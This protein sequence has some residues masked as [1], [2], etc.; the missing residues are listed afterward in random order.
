MYLSRGIYDAGFH[1][2]QKIGSQGIP[3]RQG[4]WTYVDAID[5]HTRS[6]IAFEH[7]L[8]SFEEKVK[9]LKIIIGVGNDFD[10]AACVS[11]RMWRTVRRIQR[12]DDDRMEDSRL[13]KHLNEFKE[14][15]RETSS[16][17]LSGWPEWY[18]GRNRLQGNQ[19]MMRSPYENLALEMDR[20]KNAIIQGDLFP[21]GRPPPEPFPAP[22]LGRA[23]ERAGRNC[24]SELVNFPRGGCNVMQSRKKKAKKSASSRE[25]I[26]ATNKKRKR[27]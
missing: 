1:Y 14:Y 2:D 10:N 18:F 15:M 17:Q 27:S 5:E 21:E 16:I 9:R 13:E 26:K 3:W 4:Y 24:I 8:N 6:I 7:V 22:R 19:G 11:N 20:Y 25:K 23:A 12:E